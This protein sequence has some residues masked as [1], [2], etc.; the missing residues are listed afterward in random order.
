MGSPSLLLALETQPWQLRGEGKEAPLSLVPAQVAKG[1][2]G[3]MLTAGRAALCPGGCESPRRVILLHL[4]TEGKP[5]VTGAVTKAPNTR[6][7]PGREGGTSKVGQREPVTVTV[8]LLSGEQ[9]LFLASQ[10]APLQEA[11]ERARCQLLRLSGCTPLF[12]QHPIGSTGR[13]RSVREGPHKGMGTESNG[14]RAPSRRE[15]ATSTRRSVPHS[16]LGV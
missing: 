3:H 15:P 7:R 5:G 14:H 6:T 10:H 4:L 8:C 12:P 13:P 11:Q 2:R 9:P 16:V 1:T